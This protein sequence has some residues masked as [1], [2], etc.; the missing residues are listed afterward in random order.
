MIS[1]RPKKSITEH[2]DL[3]IRGHSFRT[4]FYCILKMYALI[5]EII[6]MQRDVKL[7]FFVSELV[8]ISESQT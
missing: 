2:D 1:A 7:N 8:I 6:I 3:I 5:T 4:W